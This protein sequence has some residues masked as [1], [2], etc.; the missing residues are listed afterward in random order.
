M[1]DLASGTGKEVTQVFPP[2]AWSA[3]GADRMTNV[4]SIKQIIQKADIGKNR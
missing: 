3:Y 2:E 1:Y 4:P